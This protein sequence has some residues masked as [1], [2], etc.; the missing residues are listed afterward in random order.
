MSTLRSLTDIPLAR[1]GVNDKAKVYNRAARM[2][3]IL[4]VVVGD[5]GEGEQVQLRFTAA[6]SGIDW[7]KDRPGD[8]A[9]HETAHYRDLEESQKQ[10]AI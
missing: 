4:V 7:E 3:E 8:Q 1:N 9:S 5:I 6:T 10:V 2:R